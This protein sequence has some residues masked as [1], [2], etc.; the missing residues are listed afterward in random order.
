MYFRRRKLHQS[1]FLFYSTLFS[2]NMGDCKMRKG[3]CNYRSIHL[4]LLGSGGSGA[5]GGGT[6][7]NRPSI[8][9]SGGAKLCSF[10]VPFLT[11]RL[12]CI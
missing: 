6:S 8:P 2:I 9:T 10:S 4:A 5:G 11:A 7:N 1:A 3:K 12:I